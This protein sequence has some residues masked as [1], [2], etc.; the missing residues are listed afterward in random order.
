MLR[1]LGSGSAPV[2]KIKVPPGG[3]FLCLH[4]TT[5]PKTQSLCQH[6]ERT[7]GFILFAFRDFYQIAQSGFSAR[8][9]NPYKEIQDLAICP[10]LQRARRIQCRHGD[11]AIE[12]AAGFD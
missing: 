8:N 11:K 1:N 7:L 9:A 2:L 6:P 5:S 12:T 3:A 4:Y 10:A